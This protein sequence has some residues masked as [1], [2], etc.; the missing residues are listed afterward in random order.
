IGVSADASKGDVERAI[1]AARQ[2]FDDTEWSRDLDLRVPC[3][4]QLHQAIVDHQEEIADIT[5]AEVGAP[6]MLMGGPQLG[7]PIKFIPFY[8]DLAENYEWQQQLGVADTMAGPANR[9]VEREPVGVVA[10]ITPWNY[11]NQIN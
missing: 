11:P 4:R 2:A 9:W 3:L 1:G 10:A 5:V 6:R 7:E 8:A